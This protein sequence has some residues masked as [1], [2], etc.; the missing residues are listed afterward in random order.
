MDSSSVLTFFASGDFIQVS[1]REPDLLLTLPA[2]VGELLGFDSDILP[3]SSSKRMP[4]MCR[5]LGMSRLQRGV[6]SKGSSWE[7]GSTGSFLAGATK[8]NILLQKD[9]F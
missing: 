6:V 2:L 9:I 7:I 8:R 1:S 3:S 4:R 5:I